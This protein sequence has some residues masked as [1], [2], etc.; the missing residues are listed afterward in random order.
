MFEIRLLSEI[1][2]EACFSFLTSFKVKSLASTNS[3]LCCSGQNSYCIPFYEYSILL[4]SVK[5]SPFVAFI[6]IIIL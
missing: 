1:V 2:Q 4:L 6:F 5:Y 3:T